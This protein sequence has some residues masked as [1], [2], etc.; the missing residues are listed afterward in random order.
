MPQYQQDPSWPTQCGAAAAALASR[1]YCF[2][3][4]AALECLSEA[5]DAVRLAANRR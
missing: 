4:A 3:I 2:A 1:A 5:V